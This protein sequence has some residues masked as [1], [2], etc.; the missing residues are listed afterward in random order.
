MKKAHLLIVFLQVAIYTIAYGQTVNEKDANPITFNEIPKEFIYIHY[1]SGTLFSGETLYYKLYCLN[2]KKN[3]LST[4]S[5]IAYVELVGAGNS[6]VFKHKIRLDSGEGQGD[7]FVPVEVPSGN[8]KLIGYTQWMQNDD[9]TSF[10]EGEVTIINPYEKNRKPSTKKEGDSSYSGSVEKQSFITNS[11]STI[12]NK[13]ISLS[14]D[15]NIHKQKEKVSLTLSASNTTEGYGSYSISVRKLDG[16][17]VYPLNTAQN[18][19]S[20]YSKDQN[21]N[22]RLQFLPELRGELVSGKVVSKETDE[23][24]ANAAIALSIPGK[25]YVL[26]IASTD[27]NGRFYFNLNGDYDGENA[28]LQLLDD[29]RDGVIGIKAHSSGNYTALNFAPFRIDSDMRSIIEQ[30]SIHSQIENAYSEVRQDS[31]VPIAANYPFF[32]NKSFD[33]YDLDDYTRFPT[34]RETFIEVVQH[35]SIRSLNEKSVFNVLPNNP[36]LS[37]F[38][39]PLVVVDGIL[40]Q[41]HNAIIDYGAKNIKRILIFREKYFYGSRGY[42]GALVFETLNGDF[43]QRMYKRNTRI[44]ELFKPQP[45]KEYFNQD[46]HSEN[47]LESSH[48]PDYRYQLLWRPNIELDIPEKS[49][50]F[51]TSEVTGKFEIRLEG[52]TDTGKPVSLI[53]SLVVE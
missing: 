4:L 14:V 30:R 19:R 9:P 48:I 36:Q 21:E 46:Y 52:F 22:D 35:A 6:F 26:D 23:P 1:N 47:S 33:M 29:K 41:D 31:I 37:S 50:E 13:Y 15:V 28:I 8:Y 2:L 42:Q 3:N 32:Y 51:F 17:N 34:V 43:F 53:D 20:T 24:L 40:V 18:Y 39:P 5:K 25:A 10:F 49:I 12:S 38:Y 27:N 16:F 45:K 44:I 11:T 7:F